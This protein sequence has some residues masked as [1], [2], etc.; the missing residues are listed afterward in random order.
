[1]GRTF[2]VM[3][4]IATLTGCTLDGSVDPSKAG[5]MRCVDTRDGETFVFHQQN[6]RNVRVGIGGA[7]SCFD[8]TDSEF[9]DRHLCGSHEQWLKCSKVEEDK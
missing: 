7:D 9:K 8:V 2:A 3:A 4:V 1:M 6:A 5:L